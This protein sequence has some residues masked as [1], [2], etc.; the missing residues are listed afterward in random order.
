MLTNSLHLSKLLRTDLTCRGE[1]VLASVEISLD[2]QA[3]ADKQQH[4]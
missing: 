3:A 1:L 2:M 4:P